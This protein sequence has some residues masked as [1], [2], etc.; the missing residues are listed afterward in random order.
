MSEERMGVAGCAADSNAMFLAEH[1]ARYAVLQPYV[2]GLRVLDIACGE[3]YGSWLLREWGADS[4]VGI[5]IS[6]DAIATAKREFGREGV[7]Y[8]VG[9][10][11]AAAE[12]LDDGDFD[13]IASFETIEHVADPVG[14]LHQIKQLAAP[15]GRIFISCP[16]D[17]AALPPDQ[18]NPYHRRKYTFMQFQA[19][20]EAVLGTA[21]AWLL[22]ANVQGYGL[23]PAFVPEVHDENI[24]DMIKGTQPYHARMLPSQKNIAPDPSN[25]L[26]YM[27]VW[28]ESPTTLPVAVSAQSYKAFIEPWQALDWFKTER[29]RM[30]HAHGEMQAALDHANREA[31]GVLRQA[32]ELERV[33]RENSALNRMLVRLG[34]DLRGRANERIKEQLAEAQ[35]QIIALNAMIAYQ[36]TRAR[37]ST[38][39]MLAADAERRVNEVLR[40]KLELEQRINDLLESKSAME[41]R[42]NDLLESKLGV[43]Q[44]LDTILKTRSW[45]YTRVLRVLARLARGQFDS[46]YDSFRKW[47]R[48][49]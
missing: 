4:V 46:V 49:S 29:A 11:C 7:R 26:Y 28:G 43:E 14:F 48:Q 40:S 20:T 2:R 22:G 9:D 36:G 24:G 45:R 16:N 42:I 27:G 8:V 21:S 23:I 34:S 13:I 12:Q 30:Q 31:A 5:D 44:R 19:D 32:D 3:G 17:H 33:R 15:T 1:V 38:A 25:V 37:N 6:P 41:H 10:A 18:S 47:G 39:S 35:R